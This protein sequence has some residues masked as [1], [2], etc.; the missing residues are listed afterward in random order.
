MH[1]QYHD[2]HW[3]LAILLL[4]LIPALALAQSGDGYDLTWNTV[5]GGGVTF[6]AGGDYT[7]G[8]T[9]GQADAGLLQGGPF[10]LGGGFWGGGGT[11]QYAIYLPLVIRAAP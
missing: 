7:L 2:P 6:S 10:V 9:V 4:L 5:D 1:R 8:G 11:I 3:G